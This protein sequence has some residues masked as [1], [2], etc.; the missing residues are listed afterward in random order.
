VRIPATAS[1]AA[2][3]RGVGSLRPWFA[4]ALSLAVPGAG[5]LYARRWRRAIPFLVLTGLLLGT[6]VALW[7]RGSIFLL[8]LLV[9]PQWVWAIVVGNLAVAVLR[10]WAAFDAFWVAGGGR[11]L[12]SVSVAVAAV[13]LLGAAF[14]VPHL[15]VASKAAALL[16]ILD[17]FAREEQINRYSDLADRYP[18]TSTVDQP[19]TPPWVPHDATWRLVEGP[20]GR[21]RMQ[22]P[23]LLPSVALGP[24]DDQRITVLLAGS[25]AGPG[26]GGA[27]TDVI[28]VAT[29]DTSTNRA[30]IITVS[31]E[32]VGFP[33]PR[34]VQN[35]ASVRDFQ[36]L[37][38]DRAAAAEENGTSRATHPL[39]DEM[40]PSV[41][42]DRINSIY[43]R[44]RNLTGV[45]RGAVDPGLE[46]LAQ[47]LSQALGLRIDYYAMV[48]MGGFVD[49]V[50][51]IG[52]VSVTSREA[53]HVLVSPA[54]EGEEW[55]E[56]NIEPGR[57]RFDGRT[58]LAYVRNRTGSNDLV[59]TRRQRCMIRELAGQVDALTVVRRFEAI[60]RAVTRHVTTNIPLRL[61]PQL[62]AAVGDVNRAD[63][64]TLA[65]D[66]RS[67]SR[68]R[69][70]RNL[71][72]VNL[73]MAKRQVR[74]A[75]AGIST[76]DA[77]LPLDC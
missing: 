40:D 21:T 5:Q 73:D 46:A 47:S 63:I 43:P 66:Q 61:L 3:V 39:P 41:W 68:E 7:S 53:M 57:H 22:P 50:D 10:L 17:V 37:W 72:V 69:N 26:R 33:V 54:K 23:S 35:A 38:W 32:L 12:G 51:A 67:S 30:V 34:A 74:D 49:F 75:L 65:I 77:E 20:D 8:Q 15:F 4:A 60:S 55:I 58:A 2:P 64:G 29:V 71:P 70:Y 44:T 13:S 6:A 27:R 45:Y 1:E 48:S 24:L 16:D 14:V 11:R 19:A 9:Q 28:M 59:R 18:T 52:G 31:R 62:V 36:Q 76:P 56:I 25:D 42:L